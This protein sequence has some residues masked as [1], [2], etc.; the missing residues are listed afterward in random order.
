M[1]V[2]DIRK[3]EVPIKTESAMGQN[4]PNRIFP[5]IYGTLRVNQQGRQTLPI[6]LT[7]SITPTMLYTIFD[8]DQLIKEKFMFKCV[9]GRQQNTYFKLIF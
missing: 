2:M 6:L 4:F 1:L 9:N 8:Q 5:I 3:L 7:L